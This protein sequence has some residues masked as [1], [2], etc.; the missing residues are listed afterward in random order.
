MD[1]TEGTLAVF[2]PMEHTIQT[3]GAAW[4]NAVQHSNH[5]EKMKMDDPAMKNIPRSEVTSHLT[6]GLE[7]FKQQSKDSI[8]TR[9]CMSGE[10]FLLTNIN[11]INT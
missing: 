6:D 5:P 9:S 4:I 7:L 11:D 1:V 8:Q 2:S 3:F 10:C